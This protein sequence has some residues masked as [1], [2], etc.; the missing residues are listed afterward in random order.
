MT[1]RRCGDCQLCCRL[2]AV[3]PL[4]KLAGQRCQHQKFKTGCKVYGTS[5]MPPEC[6][7]WNCRWIVNDDM[8]DQARPD[9]SHV[10]VDIM[11]DYVTAQNLDDGTE[12]QIEVVQV[13]VDPKH[14]DAHQAPALRAYLDRRGKEGKA[15]IIRF[16][17][18]DAI[19]LF[20]PSLS[21]DGEWHEMTGKSEGQHSFTQIVRAIGGAR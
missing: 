9:R 2:L 8:Q 21:P 18:K 7:I 11:P 20:P 6:S 1:G 14:P 12:F 3:P 17:A 10:V 5:S 16:N 4:G 13:W 15:A 19:I